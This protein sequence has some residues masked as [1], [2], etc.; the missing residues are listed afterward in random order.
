MRTVIAKSGWVK[1]MPPSQSRQGLSF[2]PSGVTPCNIFPVGMSTPFFDGSSTD[3]V[4]PPSR[5]R[6]NRCRSGRPRSMAWRSGPR[7]L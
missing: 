1:S 3:Q 5:L 2:C 6:A 7:S 4:L